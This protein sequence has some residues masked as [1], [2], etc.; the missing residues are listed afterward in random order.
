MATT[1]F[2]A[3][4]NAQPAWTLLASNTPTSGSAVVFSSIPSYRSLLIA[5]QNVTLVANGGV[6]ITVNSVAGTS[7]TMGYQNGTG[8]SVTRVS[9]PNQANWQMY[10]IAGSTTLANNFTGLI[11]LDLANATTFH[12]MSGFGTTNVIGSSP[13]YFSWDGIVRDTAAITSVTLTI[14]TSTFSGTN[15]GTIYLYGAN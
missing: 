2:P 8:A 14:T 6:R 3:T 4:D 15:N 13:D 9:S 10:S 12:T 1:I 5:Y 7:Y 11:Q